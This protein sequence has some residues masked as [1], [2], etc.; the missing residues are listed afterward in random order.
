MKNENGRGMAKIISL[1]RKPLALFPA[2]FLC[3]CFSVLQVGSAP[4]QDKIFSIG[5]GPIRCMAVSPKGDLIA[6]DA[7]D[8]N[9]GVRNIVVFDLAKEQTVAIFRDLGDSL[10]LGFAFSKDGDS[11]LSYSGERLEDDVLRGRVKHW[12]IRTGEVTRNFTA[13]GYGLF[14]TSRYFVTRDMPDQKI[15]HVFDVETG[16]ELVALKRHTSKVMY[17]AA[18]LDGKYLSTS[19]RDGP[20]KVWDIPKGR[21]HLAFDFDS[22][23]RTFFLPAKSTLAIAHRTGMFYHDLASGKLLDQ[24]P[25]HSGI[26]SPDGK[27]MAA[28]GPGLM[29]NEKKPLDGLKE[30]PDGM[31]IMSFRKQD[32]IATLPYRCICVRELQY[33]PDGRFLLAGGT[34]GIVCLWDLSKL[35]P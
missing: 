12:D 20:V 28:P 1:L 27:Y 3:L 21:Q 4:G 18:S 8:F 32:I 14:I 31:Q 34:N 2:L 23:T 15:T 9:A 29:F 6:I 17:V 26:P 33:T 22:T 30:Y 25:N 7:F 5:K 35:K 16:K 19:E 13:I 10:I 11:L 24:I